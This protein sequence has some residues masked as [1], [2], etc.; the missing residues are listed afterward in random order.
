MEEHAVVHEPVGLSDAQCDAGVKHVDLIGCRAT[1]DRWRQVSSSRILQPEPAAP[2]SPV[3][4]LPSLG[5]FGAGAGVSPS[6]PQP[7]DSKVRA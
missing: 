5:Q 4:S 7:A 1:Y 3:A 6:D 2:A